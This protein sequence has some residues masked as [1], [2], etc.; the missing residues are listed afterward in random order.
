MFK[1]LFALWIFLASLSLA[2]PPA[3]AQSSIIPVSAAIHQIRYQVQQQHLSVLSS[4]PLQPNISYLSDTSP[5]RIVVDL[6]DAV[7]PAVH[8][9]IVP[10]NSAIDRIRVSQFENSPPKVR[11]VLDLRSP[12]LWQRLA[13]RV[14]PDPGRV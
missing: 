4:Q 7:F 2:A 6:P 12:L 8:Q 10:T 11:M 13:V 14:L 3:S 5:Q 1:P 9:E